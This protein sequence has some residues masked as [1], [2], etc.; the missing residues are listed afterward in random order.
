MAGTI[1]REYRS[2]GEGHR[3][4]ATPASAPAANHYPLEFSRK[5]YRILHLGFM[6]LAIVAGLDKFAYELADWSAYLA[7][8]FPRALGV[9]AT[10]FI[11]GVGC[12]EI[13]LGLGLL[14]RPRLFADLF[15]LWIGAITVNLILQGLHFDVALF[16]FGLAAGAY[17]LA[18][19]SKAKEVESTRAA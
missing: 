14:V 12:L 3:Q 17:A 10:I 5:A 15:G 18:R 6:A 19:L 4:A 11:Y 2:Y 16:N 9:S 13:L 1:K 8:V 7:A